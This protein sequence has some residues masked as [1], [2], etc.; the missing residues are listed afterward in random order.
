MRFDKFSEIR[1]KY[2]L[3]PS[4]ISCA[5]IYVQRKDEGALSFK[6]N[7][8]SLH[9]QRR[10]A[11]ILHSFPHSNMLCWSFSNALVTLVRL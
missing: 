1:T 4:K 2:P 9:N 5:C 10:K 8:C 6:Q 11:D 7:W 3:Q